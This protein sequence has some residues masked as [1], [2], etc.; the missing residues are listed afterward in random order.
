[1]K[2]KAPLL[3]SANIAIVVHVKVLFFGMLRD[4]VGRSTDE[5]DLPEGAT[6]GGVFDRYASDFPRLQ[7]YAGSIVLARNQEFSA[8]TDVV[9]SG[10]EIAFMPPVSGGTAYL[11]KIADDDGHFFALTRVAIDIDRVRRQLLQGRDG[12][13]TVFEGVVRNN[14]KGRPTERLEYECYEQM[15]G[16]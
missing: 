14:T 8:R 12:A 3:P 15:A 7:E 4:V 5:L 9:A 11:H 13:L 2:P 16:S 1:M 6:L 10:D